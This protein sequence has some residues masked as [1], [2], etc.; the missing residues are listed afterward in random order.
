M[1]YLSRR[2]K[3]TTAVLLA[4]VGFFLALAGCDE[5]GSG[6]DN[7]ANAVPP[8]EI[9]DEN[10]R[11]AISDTLETS[12]D[13]VTYD[14]LA[15]LTDLEGDG[16]GIEDL[17]GID[18]LSSLE[19]LQLGDN[20]I[21]DIDDISGLSA[22][23]IIDL[24]DTAVPSAELLSVLTSANF[25]NLATL[26][27]GGNEYLDY[28][29]NHADFAT[30]YSRFGSTIRTIRLDRVGLQDA[31]FVAIWNNVV[32]GRGDQMRTIQVR[33]NALTDAIFSTLDIS[34]IPNIEWLRLGS[35]SL[36]TPEL[37]GSLASLTRLSNLHLG[38][39]G[40]DDMAVGTLQI[41]SLTTLAAL[42]LDSNAGVTTIAFVSALTNL[43]DLQID[44]TGVDD[45]SPI[46]GL[47]L[48]RE[49][50]ISE[51]PIT[52]ISPIAGLTNLAFLDLRGSTLVTDLSPIET[53]L[54][55]GAPLQEVRING[56]GLAL[57]PTAPDPTNYNVLQALLAAGVD[58]EYEFG[59][60]I[61]AP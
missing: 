51:I 23:Q 2:L 22:L 4:L 11:Q 39:S 52:D 15:T 20:P 47:T 61:V 41:G 14:D 16:Y 27:L 21:Q 7:G 12:F 38:D 29:P 18:L 44:Q 53:A 36:A 10:L 30:V 9:P 6:G 28:T 57:Y 5:A 8:S 3:K 56:M 55:A 31:D 50:S 34:V 46:A 40:V 33:S 42:D 49:L 60:D 45:I 54:N 35:N 43:D 19:D 59:N 25:P 48:I 58:V 26:Q 13:Q 24:M 32:E 17:T 37:M 1:I